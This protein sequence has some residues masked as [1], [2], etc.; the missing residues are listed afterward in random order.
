[1]S[2]TEDFVSQVC[3]AFRKAVERASG[4]TLEGRE[5]EFRRALAQYLFDELLG[6]EEHSKVGEIYDIACFDDEDFPIIIVET[7]WR[8]EL[9]PEI[10][11]KLRKRIEELGSVKYGVFASEREFVV[12]AYRE[13]KLKD[14]AKVNVAVAVGVAKGEYGL[15]DVEMKNLQRLEMLKRERLVWLED[16]D[17]FERTYKEISVVKADGVEL[18]TVN[19]KGIVKDL[20]T[21]LMN[22]FN[23]YWK[24]TDYSGKF[25]QNA[26]NDWLKLS[27]KDEE[28]K[29]GDEEQKQKTIE[30]FCRETAYVLVG[31]ILFVRIC[32]DKEILKPSLSGREL[33]DFLKFYE[34][35]R[36][37]NVY[38]RAFEESREEIKKYY[39]HL[40]E[41]GFFDWWWVSPDKRGLLTYDDTKTQDSLEEDLNDQVKKCLRKLNRFDFTQV[42]RDILG[43]VYQGYLPSDERKRLGEFYTPKEV[44][45][46]ILDA[47]GYKP[48][49]EIRGNK[50][51]D[52]ACGSGSFL[53]E[54][55]QRLIER[56]RRIGFNLKDPDYA[57]Q[58][59]EGCISSIYGLDIHPF[60][61]FIAEMNLLFQLVDLYDVV[62]QKDRLYELPRLNIYRV[63]SLAPKGE[64]L[65]LTEFLDNSRRVLFIEE[66]KS[67]DKVK[68]IE[69]DFVVGNPPY[70]RIQRMVGLVYK[71]KQNYETAY[72]NFDLY[73]LFIEKG[74]KWLKTNGKLGF[75]CSNQ[76]MGRTYGEKL[77][78][79]ILRNC[80][81]DHILDFGDSGVFKEVTNYPCI[82]IVR[83]STQGGLFSYV[84]VFEPKIDLL[85][86][87]RKNLHL[88]VYRNASYDLFMVDQGGL[89]EDI[90]KL[91]PSKEEKIMED[92][93]KHCTHL[94][95]QISK[96]LLGLQT[97]KD[98][99][100]IVYEMKDINN[101]LVEIAPS[102]YPNATFVVER[103][104]LKPVLRGKNVR[105]W[106]IEWDGSYVIY[107]HK[108]KNDVIIPISEEEM[109]T[110]FLHT[111][112]FLKKHKQGL[113]T[114]I[115]YRKTPLQLHGSWYALM[116]YT[117]S[118]HF[119][120]PKILT[121]ALTNRNNFSLDCE[122]K[123]YFVMGTAGVYGIL[124][125]DV[126]AYFLLGLLNSKICEYYLKH[127]A[128][129]KAGGYFQYS[130]RYLEKFPIRIPQTEEEMEI[131]K[132]ISHHTKEIVRLNQIKK[133]NQERIKN[134]PASYLNNSWVFGQLANMVK[135]QN[136][137]QPAYSISEKHLR[138][139]YKQR[140][141]DGRETFRIILAT[142]EFLDFP[143][144]EVASYVLEV[145]KT[146]KNVTK[147]ELLEL[148]IPPNEHRR[149]LM[150]QYRKDNE[151]I[152]ECQKVVQNLEKQ[153][154]ELVYKLYDISY[155]ERRI[156]EEYLTKF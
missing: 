154:D 83:K 50:I 139:D 93:N 118:K 42:D 36:R 80:L 123:Y 32:E 31:R 13:Y 101:E 56:Y 53:V 61:C 37:E 73:V 125:E 143:S 144:E 26:F 44:I 148:K 12:Y 34:K 64:Y 89:T 133:E 16:P 29:K 104:L 106:E 127:I 77:R 149:N 95:G 122:G 6:W 120:K 66:T 98:K 41:L 156:I 68:S 63:D 152:V 47:V 126:D 115:W 137:L 150:I 40:H 112:D 60:A 30:L 131:A 75:I 110:K 24:R 86:D 7:K 91:S 105:R 129:I 81:I 45:E 97:G 54:S 8:V 74:I 155:A 43:D 65:E 72:A 92:I 39:S 119:Q 135:A 132:E 62:R 90:W 70:V 82:L 33:A 140:D 88:Q 96:I 17:Y 18:L 3:D 23:S 142:N 107:P 147:R 102:G 113:E 116:Y 28:F 19:L 22:F 134:F 59:I 87:I 78:S 121:P 94:L 130:V 145:L 117:T 114:R 67:A 27:I 76:F 151:Q 20:T 25:L 71:Y 1:L 100:F 79:F 49:N 153:I 2:L 128:P 109:Q 10:K 138:T 136:L 38:L 84:R 14:I 35:R 46:Y 57:K 51:L 48:E 52:P 58:I 5:R 124:P 99:L 4:V 15:S 55:M 103:E 146:M 141:L 21:V 9:T 85:K 111:F 69:F 108:R 11:E